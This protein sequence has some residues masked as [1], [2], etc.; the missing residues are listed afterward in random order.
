[1]EKQIEKILD[2]IK[3]AMKNRGLNKDITLI[4][5]IK[6]LAL[7]LRIKTSWRTDVDEKRQLM[8]RDY[9]NYEDYVSHQHDKLQRVDL[10][11]YHAHYKQ[12]LLERFQRLGVDFHRKT[13]LCLG[14]RS[15]A[16]VEAF[17]DLECF[18]V[19][20]DINPGKKNPYVLF[21]D[22]HDIQFPDKCVDIVFSNSLDHVFDVNQF[23]SEVKRVLIP[24]GI[25][26]LEISLGKNEG[27]SPGFYES[28]WW[29][30]ID[31]IVDILQANHF[32]L[33]KRY[34]IEFPWDG[35]SI[36]FRKVE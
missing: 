9:S 20:I 14:A 25:F 8:V 31:D 3:S 15:G 21:G 11:Q 10:C 6:T 16:E 35:E 4:H 2:F 1:M 33:I 7:R 13:V 30:E 5:L 23:I 19:G 29:S 24:R 12:I 28:F 22:F 18:S 27:V 34:S 26:L 36:L 17:L 32:N